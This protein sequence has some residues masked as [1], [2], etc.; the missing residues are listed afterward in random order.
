MSVTVTQWC[1]LIERLATLLGR[2]AHVDATRLDTSVQHRVL[3]VERYFGSAVASCEGA[4]AQL[5]AP[6][7][8]LAAS[9]HWRQNPTYADA[10]FLVGYGYYELFGPVGH[11]RD[12]STAIGLLLLAPHIVYPEHAH[13]ATETYLVIGGRAQW[14]QG[15]GRWRERVAGERIEHGAHEPHA[16]RTAAG[17]L[18]AAYLWHDHLHERA[19]LT[20]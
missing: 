18:L 17:P 4:T 11:V 9:L 6:L 10:D 2:P 16:M 5:R 12:D 8:A 19:R 3:P 1:E 7:E 15:D 14:R 13:A 20:R